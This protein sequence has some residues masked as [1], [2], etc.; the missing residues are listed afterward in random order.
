MMALLA[1]RREG[2]RYINP[3]PT[4]AGGLSLMFK[5]GPRFFFGAAA[6]SPGRSPGPFHTDP[7]VYATP[8]QSG[9]R[10]TWFGHSS[11]IE[12]DGVRV[13]IDPVWDKRAGPTQWIGPPTSCEPSHY[14]GSLRSGGNAEQ[15]AGTKQTCS[16][17]AQQRRS[18]GLTGPN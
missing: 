18:T 16:D 4:E 5:V 6:R 3:V 12:I 1:A 14:A 8:P 7:R 9:L 17:G 13:L 15:A 10:V 11:L 2:D